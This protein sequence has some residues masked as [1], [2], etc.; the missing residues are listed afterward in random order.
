MVAWRRLPTSRQGGG[1]SQ[2]LVFPDGTVVRAHRE[3]A[4]AAEGGL[5][6]PQLLRSM[7]SRLAPFSSRRGERQKSCRSI[8]LSPMLPEVEKDLTVSVTSGVP[9]SANDGRMLFVALVQRQAILEE[10][11]LRS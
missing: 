9:S 11:E 5:R 1:L 8:L 4:G 7:K 2:S 6:G 3:A 10:E